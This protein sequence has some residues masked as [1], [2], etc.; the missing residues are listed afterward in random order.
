MT[1]TNFAS[2]THVQWVHSN[3]MFAR[4]LTDAGWTQMKLSKEIGIAQGTI[5]RWCAGIRRPTAEHINRL[6]PLLGVTPE[7]I[8]SMFPLSEREQLVKG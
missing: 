1:K 5:S 4:A 7:S 8:V 6:S 3:S 2:T